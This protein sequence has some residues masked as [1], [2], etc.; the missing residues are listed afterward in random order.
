AETALILKQL[1]A[2]QISFNYLSRFATSEAQD[3][4]LASEE[5]FGG[6]SD[7]QMPMSHAIL[8]NAMTMDGTDGPELVANW[9]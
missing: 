3:W 8:L 7:A 6:G 5:A 2:P 9:T 4:G 1:P